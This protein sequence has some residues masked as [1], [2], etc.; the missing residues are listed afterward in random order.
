MI[1]FLLPITLALGASGCVTVYQPL[2]SLHRPV[3]VNTEENNF[4]GLHMKVRC[5]A[6]AFVKNSEAQRLCRKVERLFANQGALIDLADAKEKSDLIVDIESRLLADDTDRLFSVL[7]ILSFTLIPW[8][9]DTSLAQDITIR[10]GDGFVL[11]SDSFQA[12]FVSYFGLAVW[13]VNGLLDLIVR[14]PG[15]KLVGDAQRAVVSKDF[16]SQLSQLAFHARTRALVQRNFE[17]AK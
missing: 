17:P 4:E 11:A 13:A 5:P 9:T 1:R 3:V 8:T 16:Y 7:C 12:R 10:D 14:P 2:R 6:G 15:E